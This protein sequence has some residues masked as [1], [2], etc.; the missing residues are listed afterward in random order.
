[1]ASEECQRVIFSLIDGCSDNF[2]AVCDD[3]LILVKRDN[4][5]IF[6]A[7]GEFMK[8]FKCGEERLG[9]KNH[10]RIKQSA[11]KFLELSHGS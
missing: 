5:R 1:M 6:V 7:Q 11:E 10:L 8:C 3:D 9:E 2:A 4:G